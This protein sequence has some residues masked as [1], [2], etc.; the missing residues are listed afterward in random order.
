M[1]TKMN[2]WPN[3]K[4]EKTESSACWI[5]PYGGHLGIFTLAVSVE[6]CGQETDC[7]RLRREW[8][9]GGEDVGSMSQA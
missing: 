6:Q 4:G 9:R 2:K 5:W 1:L 8:E 3:V 7:R